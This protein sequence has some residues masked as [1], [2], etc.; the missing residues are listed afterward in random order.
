MS[1]FTAFCALAYSISFFVNPFVIGFLKISQFRYIVDEVVGI[2][3]ID[4]TSCLLHGWRQFSGHNYRHR[5]GVVRHID[6][7][8]AS[9]TAEECMSYPQFLITN[10]LHHNSCWFVLSLELPCPR[11]G[12][13]LSLPALEINEQNAP[14]KAPRSVYAHDTLKVVGILFA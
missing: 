3:A 11:N 8:H 2:G 12:A 10:R 14:R 9:R 7:I 6:V 4:T 1:F 13:V 5:F